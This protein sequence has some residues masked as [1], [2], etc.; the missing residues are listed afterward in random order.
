M[1]QLHEYNV[2][3]TGLEGEFITLF[4]RNNEH[5]I[6]GGVHGWI[7]FNYLHVDTLWLREDVRGHGHGKRLLIATEQEALKRG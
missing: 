6:V 5:L 7:A 4:L 3:Q 1:H 2:S